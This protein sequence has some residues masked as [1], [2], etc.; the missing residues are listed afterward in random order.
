MPLLV[1]FIK[2]MIF[3]YNFKKERIIIM[4]KV[5]CDKC[6]NDCDLNAYALTIQVIHN[7]TPISTN[8]FG[9]VKL[10]DDNTH[11]TLCLCQKCYGLLKLP[12]VHATV[13]TGNVVW[14]DNTGASGGAQP[15]C[16]RSVSEKPTKS[17]SHDYSSR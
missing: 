8:S 4:V 11:I 17:V 1:I 2:L 10:T 7:P 5:I 16:E 14:D 12:S 9:S 15:S 6:G 3:S 13:R